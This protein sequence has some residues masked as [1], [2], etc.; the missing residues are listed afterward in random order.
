MSWWTRSARNEDDS[1]FEL[2]GRNGRLRPV[3]GVH[4]RGGPRGPQVADPGPRWYRVTRR[5]GESIE[6]RDL[7]LVPG[8]L[9]FIPRWAEAPVVLPLDEL[10]HFRQRS[11][12][13]GSDGPAASLELEGRAAVNVKLAGFELVEGRPQPLQVFGFK[14]PI[15]IPAGVPFSLTRRLAEGFAAERAF[16]NV[17]VLEDGQRFPALVLG[18]DRASVTVMTP[19]G[20]G[21]VRLPQQRIKAVLL[22]PGT[23]LNR[24]MALTQHPF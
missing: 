4:C 1:T 24:A 23:S 2:E 22:A 21:E 17:I 19:L 7:S 20:E 12:T 18:A 15:A 5:D 16:P 6:G 9:R 3:L 8:G 14:E 13:G 11:S 10:W